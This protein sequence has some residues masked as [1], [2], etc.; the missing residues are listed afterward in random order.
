[1]NFLQLDEKLS[2]TKDFYREPNIDAVTGTPN[3]E[4]SLLLD[5]HQ[6]YNLYTCTNYLSRKISI[7]SKTFMS[8]GK[9][10]LVM[11]AE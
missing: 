11:I 1:M 5:K 4:N 7:D 8:K 10:Y 9:D 6:V 3:S 2:S